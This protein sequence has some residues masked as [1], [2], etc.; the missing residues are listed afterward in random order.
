VDG[1]RGAALEKTSYPEREHENGSACAKTDDAK[2]QTCKGD[3]V[4]T[5]SA[6]AGCDP[7]PR[8][9]THDRRPRTEHKPREPNEND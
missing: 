9:E 8:D 1:I 7:P 6:T 5:E 4:A 2:D 3:A